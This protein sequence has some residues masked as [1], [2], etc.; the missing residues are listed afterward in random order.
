MAI[1]VELFWKLSTARMDVEVT[2]IAAVGESYDGMAADIALRLDETCCG[3]A[4]EDKRVSG[5]IW[6]G[7]G[8]RSL[9]TEFMDVDIAFIASVSSPGS[10]FFASMAS[11]QIWL[12]YKG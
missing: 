1:E 5:V 4:V 12:A 6:M 10:V 11:E 9:G 3:F 7:D 8:W 2:T